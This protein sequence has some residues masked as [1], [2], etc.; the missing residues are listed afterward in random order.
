M[1]KAAL[2]PLVSIGMPV[3][4]AERYLAGALQALLAQDYSEFELII[5]DNGSRDGTEAICLEFQKLDP[6]IRYIRHPENLGAPMNFAFVAH[7]ARGEYFMWAAH[8]DLFH[9]SYV[10]KCVE[11]L[12]AHPE[13]V[14]C[15]T[16]IEFIDADGLAHSGWSNK[17]HK[18]IET[19]SMT[20][21]QRIHE[22]IARMGWFAIYGLIRKES[23]QKISLGLSVYGADVILLEELM[24]LGDFVVTDRSHR[25]SADFEGQPRDLSPCLGCGIS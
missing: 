10:Q 21:P 24:L 3:Y 7:Q 8:D 16:E 4:N 13:A 25:P 2:Q 18:N 5:A 19:P 23:L 20:P 14:L 11:K 15:C 22:L 17:G 1:N 12:A 6:R 9:P